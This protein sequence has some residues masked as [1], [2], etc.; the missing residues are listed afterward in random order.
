[1]DLLVARVKKAGFPHANELNFQEIEK[2]YPFAYQ[3]FKW[4]NLQS[5][6]NS[7]VQQAIHNPSGRA[8]AVKFTLIDTKYL[9]RKDI[10]RISDEEIK[11]LLKE[12]MLH[13][14]LSSSPYIVKFYGMCFHEIHLL[15]C[16]ELMD[17]SFKDLYRWSHSSLNTFS[18]KLLGYIV[19]I[20]INALS[21]CKDER[22]IIHRDL[23][24]DNVLIKLKTGEVKLADFGSSRILN[25]I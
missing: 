24:P 9:L 12:I 13:E 3:D 18:E 5:G 2:I 8:L 23:K 10:A 11:K 14:R 16:M 1:M 6:G 22:N 21:Y 7:F 17:L 15:N 25:G 19:V 20:I 4:T